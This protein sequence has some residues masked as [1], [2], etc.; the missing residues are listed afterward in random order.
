MGATRGSAMVS[1]EAEGAGEAQASAFPLVSVGQGKAGWADWGW[2]SLNVFRGLWDMGSGTLGQRS[3]SSWSIRDRQRRAFRVPGRT[4]WLAK[5]KC[6][7]RGVFA[8]SKNYLFLCWS[9]RPWDVKIS[10]IQKIGSKVFLNAIQSEE[11]EMYLF[12]L[13]ALSKADTF[14]GKPL[15]NL[16]QSILFFFVFLAKRFQRKLSTHRSVSVCHLYDASWT[17]PKCSVCHF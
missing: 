2:V 9:A 1:Q 8:S 10:R 15:I 6:V 4:W 3:S 11:S 5:E 13:L 12:I 17:G 7:H 14:W 16:L